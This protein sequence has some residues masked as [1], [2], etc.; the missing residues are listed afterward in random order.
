MKK[1]LIPI[2]ALASILTIGGLVS[3]SSCN[4]PTE[5]KNVAVSDVTIALSASTV[6]VGSKVTATVVVSPADATD[7]S[8]VITSSNTSVATVNGKEITGVAAGSVVITVKTT[9]GNKTATAN[10]TVEAADISVTGVT[11]SLSSS[12]VKVGAKVTATITVS[13]ADATNKNYTLTS[14]NTSIATIEGN[15]ITTIAAGEVVITAT[16]ADG[17]KVATANLTVEAIELV[18]TNP[19][20]SSYTVAA[21]ANL[22]LPSVSAAYGDTDITSSIDVQDYNDTKS[23]NATFTVFNSKIAGVHT[24][25]YYVENPNDSSQTKE[26]NISV[27]VTPNTEETLDVT[28]KNDV[29]A[30]GDYG[31]F[32][33]NFEK[34]TTSPL[35]KGMNDSNHATSLTAT[36]DAIAGNSLTLDLNKTAGSAAN[37]VF[38]TSFTDDFKRGEAVSYQVSFDYKFISECS[39]SDIYFGLSWD[40]SNGINTQFATDKTLNKVNT[41]SHK[42]T[43]VTIPATG[44]AYFF[45]FKLSASGTQTPIVAMDHFKVTAIETA[46]TTIVKPTAAQ[47]EAEGGFTFDWKEK[48]STF[49]QGE[50]TIA[51]NIADETIKTAILADTTAFGTNVMHLTGTDGHLFAGLDSSNMVA[52]KVVNIKFDYYNVND[53]AFNMIVMNAGSGTTD[54]SNL[55]MVAKSGNIKTFTW[56]HT[57]ASGEDSLNFYPASNP[58]FNIYIGNMNIYFTEAEI[59][60]EDETLLGYKVGKSWT[61]T[62]RSFGSQD[63]AFCTVTN[64]FATPETV[65]GDGIGETVTKLAYKAATNNN[66]VEWYQ[67]NNKQME[68]GNKYKIVATY[69]IES[70]PTDSRFMLNFDNNVFLALDNAVGY[71]KCEINWTATKNVDFFS[72]FIPEDSSDA[73]IYVASTVVTLTEIVK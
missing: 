67:A 2:V 8:Y 54:N 68:I 25:N 36:S 53:N 64:G 73:V 23:L 65:S 17:N 4:T 24:L 11:L 20:E 60:P 66:T 62:S 71:H 70:I 21:G 58:N 63:K 14:G 12:K 6:K 46:K 42:F 27:T 44:N 55:K 37:S 7:A 38:L 45:F 9:D 48:A 43:E 5:D 56:S 29:A 41:Y 22:N 34:G 47:L 30:I 32:E 50:T 31:T 16:T 1:R 28:G 57:I 15:E 72:F 51:A 18:L 26:L 19:G 52:G 59:V 39:D 10:L 69:Y 13:P 35:Y 49:G 61:Q 33:E 3:V 40:G